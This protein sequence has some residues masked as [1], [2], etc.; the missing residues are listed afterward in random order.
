MTKYSWLNKMGL[1]WVIWPLGS[2]LWEFDPLVEKPSISSGASRRVKAA[3]Y[4]QRCAAEASLH[5]VLPL[6]FPSFLLFNFPLLWT[7]VLTTVCPP[8]PPP[9]RSTFPDSLQKKGEIS[10]KKRRFRREHAKGG[11]MMEWTACVDGC[12]SSGKQS[13]AHSKQTRM[14][15]REKKAKL[16]NYCISIYPY[17]LVSFKLAG[18]QILLPFNRLNKPATPP[19]FFQSSNLGLAARFN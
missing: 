6:P 7:V 3:H 12:T 5:S 17:I 4:I 19:F 1:L 9:E 11:A 2:W 16:L 8:F 15:Q 18:S 13:A 14:A 10:P